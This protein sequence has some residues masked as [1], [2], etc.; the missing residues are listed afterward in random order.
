MPRVPLLAGS[1]LAIVD[2]GERSL[3]LRPPAPP[4]HGLADV[5]AAVREAAR[6]P[7]EGEPLE[8]LATPGGTATIVVEPPVLPLPGS[9]RD[10]RQEAIAAVVE[11]LERAGVPPARQTI[12][13]AGGLARRQGPREIGSLVTPEFRR[14]FRG[15]LVVHD[16]ERADLV[17]VGQHDGLPLRVAPQ[18]TETDA[19]VTVTAA[20]TVL[21]GGPAALLG[22]SGPA[23]LRAAAARSLLETA[24]S[25]G[26]ALARE[27]ERALA[28]RVPVFGVSLALNHARPV[29]VARG[30]P[31]EAGAVERLA[32]SP[33]SRAFGLLPGAL[34]RQLLSGVPI[35]L[36]AAG[37][38]GGPPSVAHAEALLRSIE[39]RSIILERPL[40]AICI[41][42]PHVT[43]PLPRERPNPL[44]VAYLGLGLA[45]RLWRDRFPVLDG[46]TAILVHRFKRTFAHPTQRP[47]RT[48]FGPHALRESIESAEE[49]LATDPELIEQ[50]RR[51]RTHH[52]LLPFVELDACRPARDRLGRVLVAGCR[53][54]A[55]ARALRLVP[56]HNL[57][58]ALSMAT[59]RTG[60][61]ARV[62]F[63][64]APPYSPLVVRS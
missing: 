50:Y 20:E 40:D 41:G 10:P 43:V 19:V 57:Q 11:E 59:G 38:F 3:V 51:G 27:L 25:R 52:P 9:L 62:G 56:A 15:K 33:L 17:E 34:R 58:A 7:L 22:A 2:T 4:E 61:D 44:S 46:G 36:T 28:S 23:E 55:A 53:D 30:F 1:R 18:L 54:A 60:A 49:S 45:L 29:G 6:F 47:Y 31:F 21:H 16:V 24:G 48:L 37:A 13:V 64:L 35:E 26:W 32:R 39:L 63:V 14:R 12:V 5:A 42:I 8:R